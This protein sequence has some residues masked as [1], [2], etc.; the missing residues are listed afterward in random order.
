MSDAL[1][2]WPL[3]YLLHSTLLLG[4]AW[5]ASR[6]VRHAG[7][8]E[9]LWR[10]AFFGAFVTA[11]LQP[12][13]QLVPARAA[14]PSPVQ[15]AAP[16]PARVTPLRAQPP[17]PPAPAMAPVLASVPHA[18][19]NPR[20]WRV[21]LPQQ[22]RL[23]L[24]AASLA[25]ALVAATGLLA[26]VLRWLALARACGRLRPNVD[27]GW[28]LSLREL[29][30]H[31]GLGREPALRV[32]SAWASP[33]VGPRGVV[34]LPD[35]CLAQLQGAQRDAVLA[36]ELAHLA[37]RDPAWRLAARAAA[38]LGWMQPLNVIA[39]RR[40]DALAEQACD[41][42][43]ARAIADRQA[44]AEALFACAS[45]LVSGRRAP[46]LQPGM[47]ATR[48]PLVQRI[49][50]L[51][52]PEPAHDA[53]RARRRAWWLLALVPV[54]GACLVP[55]IAVRGRA[56]HTGDWRQ[57]WEDS[58]PGSGT[59]VMMR[60]P[61][62]QVDLWIRDSA[63][64]RDDSDDLAGGHVTL[65]ETVDGITRRMEIDAR[66]GTA[67]RRYE[68]D[69]EP[70]PLDADMKRWADRR[71]EMVMGTLLR[72]AQRID[73]LLRR[74]GPELVMQSIEH[75]VDI[76]TQHEFIEAWAGQRTLDDSTVQRLIAAVDLAEPAGDDHD[77][78]L[79]LREIARRQPLVGARRE[80]LLAA[81]ATRRHEPDTASALQA[82]LA[83]FDAQ[84]SAQAVAASADLLRALPSDEQRRETLAQ[85]LDAGAAIAPELALQLAPAFT[86]DFDSRALLEHVARRLATGDRGEMVVR[87]ADAARRIRSPGERRLALVALLEAMPVRA[88]GGLAVL[89]ALDGVSNPD[90]LTPVLL[91]LARRM[92]PDPALIA[93][94]RQVARVL[95]AYERGQVEQALDAL[96][97][98][99]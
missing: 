60:S 13:A 28:A 14:T 95:P 31:N 19:S 34:C 24:L 42:R 26:L 70:H 62:D 50:H 55:V 90:E 83:Q 88:D 61:G 52:Q 77:R 69:G 74:G 97:Q 43:A 99:G 44:V 38:C 8:A 82:V 51:M 91:A 12:L 11:T 66:S 98:P 85:P 18:V 81:L 59:H 63:T 36:H 89:A 17:A 40:L 71:W 5:L 58:M 49:E 48:S 46:R 53:P 87:Y 54:V 65:R 94:Y 9:T 30:Q 16:A 57:L 41:A 79:S 39:L 35:W 75:P 10:C 78:V 68:L 3:A 67:V 25:W 33:L 27:G 4:G 20:S 22:A 72:P 92:P 56:L 47:A 84:T 86:S 23:A 37:R 96:P 29:A 76:D 15:A 2:L 1:L 7:L 21:W 6:W 73:R 45:Q 32:G 64:L 80:Q 93:R